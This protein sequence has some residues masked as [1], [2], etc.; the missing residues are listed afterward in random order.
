MLTVTAVVQ[1]AVEDGGGDDAIAEHVSPAAERLV[2]GE[3]ERPLLVAPADELEEQVGTALVDR[4][5]SR[6]RR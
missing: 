2:A 4:E 1:D 6:S 3:D 5:V